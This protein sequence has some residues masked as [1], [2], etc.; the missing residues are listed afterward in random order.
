MTNHNDIDVLFTYCRYLLGKLWEIR[1]YVD[2][3]MVGKT[4]LG[5]DEFIE[6]MAADGDPEVPEYISELRSRYEGNQ[7]QL[8]EISS[9]LKKIEWLGENTDPRHRENYTRRLGEIANAEEVRQ[10]MKEYGNERTKKD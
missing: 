4:K 10:K 9:N 2:R 7:K 6:L 8:F 5:A 3:K 1:V